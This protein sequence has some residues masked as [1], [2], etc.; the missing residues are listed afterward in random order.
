ARVRA[1][2]DGGACGVDGPYPGQRRRPA[3][4]LGGPEHDGRGRRADGRLLGR[5]RPRRAGAER[6]PARADGRR[7]SSAGGLSAAG[8]QGVPDLRHHPPCGDQRRVGAGAM[9]SDNPA[10]VVLVSTTIMDGTVVRW[11]RSLTDAET[12]RPVVSASRYGVMTGRDVYLTD[13]PRAWVSAATE[14]Y[15]KLQANPRAD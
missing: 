9:S 3:Q 2:G 7:P 4:G 10:P 1:A 12:K 5:F 15:K 11:H 14:A 6:R 13:V 8:R